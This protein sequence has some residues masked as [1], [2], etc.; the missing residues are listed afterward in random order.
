MNKHCIEYIYKK[1]IYYE[2]NKCK[3]VLFCRW[4]NN[5]PSY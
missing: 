2:S 4:G 5:V 1:K 3:L